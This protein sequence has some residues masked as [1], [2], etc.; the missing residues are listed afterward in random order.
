MG[1]QSHSVVDIVSHFNGRQIESCD[2]KIVPYEIPTGNLAAY[3]PEA[4]A[5]VPL[6][7]V[8]IGSNTPTSKSIEVSIIKHKD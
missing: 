3:F 4:N 1:L 6:E 7:S 2:W 8:A 5:L